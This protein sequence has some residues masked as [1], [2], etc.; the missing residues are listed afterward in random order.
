[1]IF[2]PGFL[3]REYKAGRRASYL[4]PV[5]M[6]LF[7]SAIFFLI[8]FSVTG[9]RDNNDKAKY[10]G[11]TIAEIEKMDSL[12][13]RDFTAK[14]NHGVPMSR[15]KFNLYIDSVKNLG[16]FRIS[17]GKYSTREAYDSAIKSGKINDNWLERK[18]T[19][20]GIEMEK[21][22]NNDQKAI[23][24]AFF[25][26]L[27]HSFPQMLFISLPIFAF[28][29]QIL[30]RRQKDFYYVSNAIFSIHLYIFVFIMMFIVL[31][32]GKVNL[33]MDWSWLNYVSWLVFGLIFFYLYKAM[34]N[35]YQQGRGKTIL[36]FILLNIGAA[37]MIILLFII[38][39][40]FSLLKM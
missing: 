36:K 13:F 19:Y 1:M 3:S 32:L 22:Y 31:M 17:T 25:E 33:Y 18:L 8:F 24:K 28:L 21:K 15:T 2:R 30:Y 16:G 12:Q 34:R 5:R 14:N 11:K 29:L 9:Y 23:T 4:N 37:I 7:T 38:F 26:N 6:Y 10:N 40:F 27:M 20:R 35:F 39:F